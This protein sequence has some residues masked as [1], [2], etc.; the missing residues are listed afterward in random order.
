MRGGGA[1]EWVEASSQQKTEAKANV[2]GGHVV[3]ILYLF[4]PGFVLLLFEYLFCGCVCLC[5]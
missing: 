2:I 3:P 4:C 5:R 1:D